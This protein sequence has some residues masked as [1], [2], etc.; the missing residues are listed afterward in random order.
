MQ[1]TFHRWVQKLLELQSVVNTYLSCGHVYLHSV[2]IMAIGWVD[3]VVCRRRRMHVLGRWRCF[4]VG[5]VRAVIE[6]TYATLK[7]KEFNVHKVH[8]GEIKGNKIK[9]ALFVLL[10]TKKPTF[11]PICYLTR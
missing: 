10:G 1:S 3:V 11:F 9:K 2:A 4:F 6:Q 5:Y 7:L 8:K